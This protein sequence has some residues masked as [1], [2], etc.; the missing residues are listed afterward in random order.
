MFLWDGRMRVI[1]CPH[2]AAS[3]C[4][5]RAINARGDVVGDA[6][7]DVIDGGYAF[8]YYRDGTFHRLDELIDANGWTFK[9]AVGINDAGQITGWGTVNGEG[10]AFVLTPR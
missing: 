9:Y 5:P 8:L 3:Y 10:H 4:W 7:I 6:L 2:D 1:G